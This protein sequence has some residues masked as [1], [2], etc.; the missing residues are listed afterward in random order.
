MPPTVSAISCSIWMEMSVSGSF[1]DWVARQTAAT[2][3][4]NVNSVR[5]VQQAIEAEARRQI[6]VLED[7]G[8][9]AQETRL[10]DP[11]TGQGRTMRTKEDAHDYRYK[12]DGNIFL[13]W[14]WTNH[15]FWN[16]IV[17]SFVFY[18]FII[19]NFV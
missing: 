6:A 2:E 11:S 1:Q 4:K 7:G 3:T 5:F 10:F 8:E 19:P 9:I 15:G 18:Y 13:V 12:I 17:F 14:F 16:R